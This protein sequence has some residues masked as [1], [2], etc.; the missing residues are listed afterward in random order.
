M[1]SSAKL[2]L[3]NE[4]TWP[5]LDFKSFYMVRQHLRLILNEK[6]A[7]KGYIW[8]M[9]HF[10]PSNRCSFRCDSIPYYYFQ[11][12]STM[13]RMRIF[14]KNTISDYRVKLVSPIMCF[15][16]LRQRLF[17]YRFYTKFSVSHIS[18]QSELSLKR[19]FFQKQNYK[20]KLYEPMNAIYS[21]VTVIVVFIG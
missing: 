5:K 6:Y 17:E 16:S 19:I 4:F 8:L 2:S 15:Q 20:I 10:H 21:F 7:V 1:G 12:Q 3:Q 14:S 13:L 18:I 9:N 11:Y